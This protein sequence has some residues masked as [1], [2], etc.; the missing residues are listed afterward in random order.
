MSHIEGWISLGQSASTPCFRAATSEP[1]IADAEAVGGIA[2]NDSCRFLILTTA[3]VCKALEDATG[4]TQVNRD[5]AAL[6]LKEF[7]TQSTI[8]GVAQAVVDEISR[9]HYDAFV[10]D[11]AGGAAG[12]RSFICQKREDMTLMVRNF[13]QPLAPPSASSTPSFATLLSG[14]GRTM[15]PEISLTR[16]S[17]AAEDTWTLGGTTSSSWSRDDSPP[18]IYTLPLDENGR[19]AAYVD[20]NEFF[21]AVKKMETDAAEAKVRR[22]SSENPPGTDSQ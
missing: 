3:S 18:Q 4:S 1:V 15:T 8:N 17:A 13:N 14:G 16:P 9:R 19:V 10:G 22:Q 2:L 20:F 5:L 12:D 7:G 11:A 21:D 6:V